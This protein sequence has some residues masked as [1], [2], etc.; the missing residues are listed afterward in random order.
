MIGSGGREHAI[1][2]RLAQSGHEVIGAPGNPGTEEIGIRVDSSDYLVVA[3]E[4][5][6][7]LT[8]VGPEAPLVA[9][10]VDQFRAEGLPIVGPDRERARLEGSKTFA[11]KFMEQAGIPTARARYAATTN[12]AV[13]SLD[14]FTYPVVIKAD[15]LAGGKGVVIAEDRA[16]A[17]A[18]I[19]R[20]GPPLLVEEFLDGEEVSFIVLSDGRDFVPLEASQDHKRL[21]D[22]DDGPNTGGMGA[23]TDGRIL[24]AADHDRVVREIIA[25]TIEKT[26]F[27]GFLYAGLMMTAEG[28]RVLEYN[29]RLG[30]P[31]TQPL[32]HRMQ[33]DFGE[34][35]WRAAKKELRGAAI[36]WSKEPSVCVVMAAPGYPE[37][38][39]V[40]LPIEGIEDAPATVFQAGTR[41]Q[42]EAL[43]TAGG[44]VLGITARGSDLRTAADNA[45]AAVSC[46]HF[47]GAQYRR[48]ISRKGW[49]RW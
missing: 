47:D 3:R 31:E 1:G 29:V 33:G 2:W 32:L 8:V 25:P 21:L 16:A 43:V 42:G 39:E 18:A 46:I 7:D 45:Y 23:Y 15:G 17:V 36:G 24:S 19:N 26:G 13:W 40:G 20:L 41:R 4:Q 44:R 30:D 9:G 34:L 28:P 11:K 14:S 49:K 48:D 38:P 27:T 35:L 10:V 5:A 12:E 6:V 22:N 37:A